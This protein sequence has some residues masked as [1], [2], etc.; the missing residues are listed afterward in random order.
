MNSQKKA[1]GWLEWLL[2]KLSNDPAF[3]PTR[4]VVAIKSEASNEIP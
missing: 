1:T 2:H 3:L 4:K